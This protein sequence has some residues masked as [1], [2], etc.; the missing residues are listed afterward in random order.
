MIIEFLSHSRSEKKSFDESD[1]LEKKYFIKDNYR[2]I[3]KKLI[4]DIAKARINE[5]VDIILN[6]NINLNSFKHK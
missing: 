6:K 3:R 4:F 2:K 5:I 1:L